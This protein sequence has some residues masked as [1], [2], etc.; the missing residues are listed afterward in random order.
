MRSLSDDNLLLLA[1]SQ[2]KATYG[3]APDFTRTVA[4][5]FEA[6]KRERWMQ[7]R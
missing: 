2:V 3:D 6:L 1:I 4:V 5:A 7:S